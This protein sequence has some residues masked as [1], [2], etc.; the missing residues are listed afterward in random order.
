MAE[1]KDILEALILGQ[2]RQAEDR[3]K[4]ENNEDRR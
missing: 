3:K 2:R 4:S 1:L